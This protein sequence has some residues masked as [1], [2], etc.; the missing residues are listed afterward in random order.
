MKKWTVILDVTPTAAYHIE[1][2]KFVW[3]DNYV[4]F[5]DE[6]GLPVATFSAR[7]VVSI[8]RGQDMPAE[9]DPD[10]PEAHGVDPA[11]E[12]ARDAAQSEVEA[13]RS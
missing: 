7:L 6:I 1:A 4:E 13:D 12:A 5:L 11:Y 9:K 3:Q 2:E 10:G 8:E